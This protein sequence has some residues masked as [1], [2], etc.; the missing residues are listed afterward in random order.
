MKRLIL[1]G[2]LFVLLLALA[3]GCS[4]KARFDGC[5]D[6]QDCPA[7]QAC[8]A[9]VCE[10]VECRADGDCEAGQSCV[11]YACVAQ[12]ACTSDG[13]CAVGTICVDSTCQAGCRVDGDCPDGSLCVPDLGAHG[14][15]ADCRWD[16]D[17][18]VD[19]RC[20]DNDCRSE[21]QSDADCPGGHCDP[22]TTTCVDCLQDADC[23][24]G[25]ICQTHVC[26]AGCRQDADCPAGQ[27][28]Q[29]LTCQPGCRQDSDCADG[30]IC[31]A[32]ACRPGCRLDQDCPDGICDPDSL[33]CLGVDCLGSADCQ[34]GQICVAGQCVTGCEATRDCP[35]GMVCDP[36]SGPNGLCVDCLVDGDCPSQHT[37]VAQECV[38]PEGECDLQIVPADPVEFPAVPVGGIASQSF[39]LTNAGFGG[40]LITNL[41]LREANAGDQPNFQIIAAPSLPLVLAPSGQAGDRA[42]I[43]VL[44]VPVRVGAQAATFWLRSNDPDLDLGRNEPA[45]GPA[46]N[47]VLGQACVPLSGN[48]TAGCDGLAVMPQPVLFG[49]VIAGCDSLDRNVRIYNVGQIARTINTLAVDPAADEGFSILQAPAL[50]VTLQPGA[51]LEVDLRFTAS[52]P[53]LATANLLVGTAISGCQVAVPLIALVVED[54]AAEDVFAQP[55]SPQVDVLWVVDNSGSMT[56]VQEALAAASVEF[57]R[58]AVQIG[59][60]FQIGVVTTDMDD[61]TQS[62]RLQGDP[63]IITP[64]TPN[65]EAAF[66]ANVQVGNQGSAYEQGLAPV[67]AALTEPLRSGANAGFYRP[68]AKLNVIWVSDEDDQSPMGTD[69]YADFFI[70]LKGY[71]ELFDLSAVVGD[72]PAGCSSAD[73]AINAVAGTRY[74]ELVD[75]LW[76]M[77]QSVCDPDWAALWQH[78]G[79]IDLTPQRSFVLSRP[80]LEATIEARIDG[81]LVPQAAQDFGADGWTY[82]G[83]VN[84]LWF[85]DNVIPPYG[86]VLTIQYTADCP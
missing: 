67:V 10:A 70:Q 64:D 73:G 48:G 8:L 41:E 52:T 79:M 28:C 34:L 68:A 5:V 30:Q 55:L 85:G 53:G 36:S 6:D 76:G 24:A 63:L 62:G 21:C 60:D 72:A 83:L 84:G 11:E 49:E 16:G 18:P 47:W 17:C 44:F 12:G 43:E 51:R 38:P 22:Q 14:E 37:C 86:A 35:Q 23:A 39:T 46:G 4:S 74:L 40:C 65:A 78:L 13:Q 54:P 57:I 61:P 19:Q 45:C 15:C 69:F 2:S 59:L 56:P 66:A 80:A 25:Q 77:F 81:L 32:L 50:P 1:D 26:Q 75:G 58:W 71:L 82:S 29:A 9:N 31:E 20:V 7:G 27:V 3:A 33:T 42:V